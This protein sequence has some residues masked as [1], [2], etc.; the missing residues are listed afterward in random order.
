MALRAKWTVRMEGLETRLAAGGSDGEPELHLVRVSLVINALTPDT[1]G[2][3]DD[4]VDHAAICH[5]IAHQWPLSPAAPLLETRVN[6][7][8]DFVFAFDKRV[9]DVWVG[10]DQPLAAPQGARVGVERKR[11]RRQFEDRMRALDY[12][13]R[14][15]RTA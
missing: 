6:E 13:V 7:L 11:T 8:L 14:L 4:C 10:L 1:P 3:P 5:W 9:Q 12:H 2:E 15:S